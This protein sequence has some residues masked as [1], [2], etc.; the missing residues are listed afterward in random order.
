MII[1][2][3]FTDIDVFRVVATSPRTV[4]ALVVL[5]N[6]FGS[7]Q[8]DS[9]GMGPTLGGVSLHSVH[10]IS[11]PTSAMSCSGARAALPLVASWVT[12]L[13]GHHKTCGAN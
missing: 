7:F 2:C 5:K 1:L 4:A 13:I 3:S 9:D 12:S 10:R 11:M 8:N 6:R